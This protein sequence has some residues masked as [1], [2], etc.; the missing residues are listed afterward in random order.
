MWLQGI[1]WVGAVSLAPGSPEQYSPHETL[2]AEVSIG[3]D[4]RGLCSQTMEDLQ[5][6]VVARAIGI[7]E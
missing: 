4:C 7:L 3:A 2:S 1:T 6:E 5:M